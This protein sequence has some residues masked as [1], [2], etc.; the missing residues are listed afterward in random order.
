[1]KKIVIVLTV[2]FAAGCAGTGG[3]NSSG[4]SSGSGGSGS[5]TDTSDIYQPNFAPA[6]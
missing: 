3:M 2:M 5:G 4:Y 6:H 1:M